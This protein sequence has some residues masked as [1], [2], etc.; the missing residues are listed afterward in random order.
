M[1]D[2]VLISTLA[3]HGTLLK[4]GNSLPK[5]ILLRL[6]ASASRCSWLRYSTD[7]EVPAS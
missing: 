3:Q 1:Q 2:R 5:I 7:V 4:Y 6:D